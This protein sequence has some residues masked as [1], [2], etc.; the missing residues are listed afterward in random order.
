VGLAQSKCSSVERVQLWH[1]GCYP[2]TTR[3]LGMIAGVIT[4]RD[5]LLHSASIVND[6][7]LRAW[8]RCCKAVLTK[9]R[10]TF[11]ELMWLG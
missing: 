3:R 11:L 8:L 10:T 4:T 5:V 7:G 9:R 6:F 1:G 2:D